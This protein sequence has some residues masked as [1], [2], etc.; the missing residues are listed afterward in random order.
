MG[1][2]IQS[3]SRCATQEERGHRGG[4]LHHELRPRRNVFSHGPSEQSRYCAI[5]SSLAS[6]LPSY[7]GLLLPPSRL[8]HE[9]RCALEVAVVVANDEVL[10]GPVPDGKTS[11]GGGLVLEA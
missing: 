3:P 9:V 4:S 8:I 10:P 1:D 2:V 6:G 5:N 7:V 11:G